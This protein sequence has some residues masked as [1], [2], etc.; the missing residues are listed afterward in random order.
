MTGSTRR[1]FLQGMGATVLT[2]AV[3][4]CME[5]SL[6]GE[7]DGEA[8]TGWIP[9]PQTK[10]DHVPIRVTRLK[11][12]LSNR[13]QFG[14]PLKSWLTEFRKTVGRLHSDVA[15]F[16]TVIESRRTLIARG[17]FSTNDIKNSYSSLG[18]SRSGEHK[19]YTLYGGWWGK[20]IGLRNGA[21][22]YGPEESIK[23][24]IDAKLDEKNRYTDQKSFAHLT[25]QLGTADLITTGP[26][27]FGPPMYERET[28]GGIAYSLD[29]D[30]TQATLA[31][32]FDASR[33]VGKQRVK[34]RL[35]D[36]AV[37]T[38]G[39]TVSF[40]Q[41]SGQM[42]ATASLPTKKIPQPNL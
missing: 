35:R 5:G 1:R 40:S 9:A 36:T 8:Y 19:G 23:R 17:P 30:T 6:T 22:L 25:K 38:A 27:P 28:L 16:K 33:S 29:G 41:K 12:L 26:T 24:H 32:Q 13:D 2:A 20:T 4:G 37:L 18:D 39:S 10:T 42:V 11:T 7:N 15:Q 34:K 31:T 14:D 3:A 21:L